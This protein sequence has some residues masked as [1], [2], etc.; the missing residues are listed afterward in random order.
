VWLA[1]VFL[2][3]SGS[4]GIKYQRERLSQFSIVAATRLDSETIWFYLKRSEGYLQSKDLQSKF[5]SQFLVFRLRCPKTA[6]LKIPPPKS[7]I[8]KTEGHTVARIRAPQTGNRIKGCHPEHSEGTWVCVQ[9][10]CRR[11]Q[12]ERSR[13]G[14]HLEI[15]WD[16]PLTGFSAA[17]YVCRV[18][19]TV[20][21][22]LV[23]LRTGLNSRRPGGPRFGL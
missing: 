19:R 9:L 23:C 8:S 14:N 22:A 16:A 20:G 15:L 10:S 4:S 21:V 6:R 17:R 1:G 11:S 12:P 5:F 3:L 18:S 7:A 2:Q 13:C